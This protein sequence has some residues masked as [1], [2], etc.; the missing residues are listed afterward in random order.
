M[1]SHKTSLY[2]QNFFQVGKTQSFYVRIYSF[3]VL[4]IVS[5]MAEAKSLR[6]RFVLRQPSPGA[7]AST[8]MRLLSGSVVPLVASFQKKKNI[9]IGIYLQCLY[10][11]IFQFFFFQVEKN[12]YNR[13][14]CYCYTGN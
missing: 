11:T 9:Y 10:P 6:L 2:P 1:S 12:F 8:T 5:R 7:F 13:K 14:Q 3:W 4:S